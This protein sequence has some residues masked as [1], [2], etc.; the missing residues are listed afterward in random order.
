MGVETQ[1]TTQKLKD[2]A[3]LYRV[4]TPSTSKNRAQEMQN[5]LHSRNVDAIVIS[6]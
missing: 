1:I 6:K 4:H 2:G 3:T 5:R